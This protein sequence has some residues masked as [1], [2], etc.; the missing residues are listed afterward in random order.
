MR[1]ELSLEEEITLWQEGNIESMH[2]VLKQLLQL[3]P[4]LQE[5]NL[6]CVL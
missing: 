2:S 3:I 1:S 6:N 5:M 4:L